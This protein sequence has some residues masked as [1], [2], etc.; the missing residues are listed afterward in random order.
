MLHREI[1]RDKMATKKKYQVTAFGRRLPS[2]MQV[3]PLDPKQ[4]RKWQYCERVPE[5][6]ASMAASKL[7]VYSFFSCRSTK[8]F[9]EYIFNEKVE[10]KPPKYLIDTGMMDPQSFGVR[11]ESMTMREDSFGDVS[12]MVSLF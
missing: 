5:K 10:I 12:R 8:A 2:E 11:R 7:C 3:R 4:Y 1:R 6:I 9:C